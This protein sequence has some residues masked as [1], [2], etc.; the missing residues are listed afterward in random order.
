[1]GKFKRDQKI[2]AFYYPDDSQIVF[3][4]NGVEKITVIMEDGQMSGVPW[5]AVWRDG[6]IDSKHNAA[7]IASVTL[8]PNKPQ[9][10][11]H[12]ASIATERHPQTSGSITHCAAEYGIEGTGTQ[13]G[14][15]ERQ[16]LE[17][18]TICGLLA[19]ITLGVWF[20]LNAI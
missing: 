3:G 17:I 4:Q 13:G 15:H 20:F 10:W 6:K 7:H 5:F 18:A 12:R 9:G 11:T 1:M 16:I 2:A 19:L 14:S 8:Q